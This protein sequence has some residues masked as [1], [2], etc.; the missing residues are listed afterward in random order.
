[1]ASTVMSVRL[2]DE[3]RVLAEKLA[4]DRGVSVGDLI[5]S[6]IRESKN[7]DVLQ[8]ILLNTTFLRAATAVQVSNS[9]HRQEVVELWEE[10]K[11][12]ITGGNAA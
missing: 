11:K 2:S 7:A 5:R 6:L 10:E 3:E 12:K 8:T 4:G 1:M 9:P